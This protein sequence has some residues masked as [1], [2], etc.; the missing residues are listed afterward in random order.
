AGRLRM[1]ENIEIRFDSLFTGEDDRATIN[2]VFPLVEI[3]FAAFF[4]ADAAGETGTIVVPHQAS[5]DIELCLGQVVVH[6]QRILRLDSEVIE[7]ALQHG[8]TFLS[9]VQLRR[10]VQITGQSLVEIEL[11]SI[12]TFDNVHLAAEQVAI[13][14]RAQGDGCVGYRL[15][16]LRVFNVD[17][18]SLNAQSDI[19]KIAVRVSE[20][21]V[22]RE[23][24]SVQRAAQLPD[25]DS[26]AV[27]VHTE[28]QIVGLNSG[29]RHAEYALLQFDESAGDRKS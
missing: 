9:E 16:V 12:G 24:S 1:R 2:Q 8:V 25:I 21:A 10:L 22:T 23:R 19:G 15:E 13:A 14:P 3:E 26:V 4:N 7:Q 5:I 27:D 11:S 17:V 20:A 29:R 6:H 18:F 28:I